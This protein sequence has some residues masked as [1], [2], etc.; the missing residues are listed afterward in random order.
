MG[1][2]IYRDSLS[3]WKG[4]REI[5]GLE[6]DGR[7]E[8]LASQL[9]DQLDPGAFDLEAALARA[10]T[11]QFLQALF[12][13]VQPFVGMF[14]DILSFFERAGARHGQSQWKVGIGDE[15]IDLRHFEELLERW[16]SI[17]CEVEV[18]ALDRASAF[19]FNNIRRE[20]G[21]D[22]LREGSAPD[23]PI[24]TGVTDA[25]SWLADYFAG[26]H[27][28]EASILISCRPALMTQLVS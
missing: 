24:V 28:L 1:T 13:T 17:D 2:E 22:Y 8:D 11:D 3:A 10:S 25:D 19:I 9:K 18:P 27:S 5:G 12:Q 15:F 4:L 14:R 20:V 26:R 23:K 7:D 16:A 6:L 21:D